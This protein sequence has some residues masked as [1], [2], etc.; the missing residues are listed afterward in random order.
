MVPYKEMEIQKGKKYKAEF[1]SGSSLRKRDIK[2]W[3]NALKMVGENRKVLLII[4]ERELNL[5]EI[6]Q[7]RRFFCKRAKEIGKNCIYLLAFGKVEVKDLE[8]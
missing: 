7:Y 3:N 5:K 6:E 8:E 4:P 1:T 2:A